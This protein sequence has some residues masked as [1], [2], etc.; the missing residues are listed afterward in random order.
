MGAVNGD[1]PPPVFFLSVDSKGNQ[2]GCFHTDL[3][4]LVLM[5]LEEAAR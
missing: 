1:D 5:G 3:K 2:V 4:V